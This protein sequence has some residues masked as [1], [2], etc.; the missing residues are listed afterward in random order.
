MGGIDLG[1][2]YTH[3]WKKEA[4]KS[5]S[6]LENTK[7]EKY[8]TNEFYSY[9]VQFKEKN[10]PNEQKIFFPFLGSIQLGLSLFFI[11]SKISQMQ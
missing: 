2:N 1:I 8:L 7:K 6:L 11:V 3:L 10:E 5:H 9:W 4:K